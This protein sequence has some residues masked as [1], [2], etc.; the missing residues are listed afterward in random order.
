MEI[1]A[2]PTFVFVSGEAH[3]LSWVDGV[4]GP[5][6][7]AI[8]SYASSAPLHSWRAAVEGVPA[9]HAAIVVTID[10]VVSSTV[11]AVWTKE[12]KFKSLRNYSIIHNKP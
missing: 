6:S 10:K 7:A 2:S 9:C 5:A 12:E 1:K 11:P 8:T 3:L 4:E